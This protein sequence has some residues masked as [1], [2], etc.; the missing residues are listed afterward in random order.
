[1]S[2]N[3]ASLPCIIG[4]DL[5]LTAT[6]VANIRGNAMST[7]T[8]RS[9]GKADDGLLTRGNRL[10]KLADEVTAWASLGDV[11]IIEQPAYGQTGGSHHDRSGLWWLVMDAL[12]DDILFERFAEVTPQGVK[13]YATGKG[14]ASKSEVRC[15]PPEDS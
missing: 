10:H 6:G 13:M 8:I 9:K 4:L 2:D 12:T 11:I 5:S 14:N 7:R 3:L 15:D 1:M